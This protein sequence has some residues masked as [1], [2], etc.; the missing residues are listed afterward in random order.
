MVTKE[1][2]SCSCKTCRWWMWMLIAS[3]SLAQEQISVGGNCC[4]GN[5]VGNIQTINLCVKVN[6]QVLNHL[7][8]QRCY[9]QWLVS[10]LLRER[11]GRRNL[12]HK[13][14]CLLSCGSPPQPLLVI[15]CRPTW[16]CKMWLCEASQM[17][18]GQ[19]G[20]ADPLTRG[21]TRQPDAVS[22]K[23]RACFTES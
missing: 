22:V 6:P 2:P 23:G 7:I 10:A 19:L 13:S 12:E 20:L 5:N 18:A 21:T 4:K 8:T 11:D 1:E 9:R 17:Q 16:L 15:A 3:G 14:H